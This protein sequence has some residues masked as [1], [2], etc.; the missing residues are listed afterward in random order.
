MATGV[1]VS[2][3]NLYAVVD[4]MADTARITQSI[5]EVATLQNGAVQIT[6]AVIE[7]AVGLGVSCNNPPGGIAGL[8]YTHTFLAGSGD[9]PYTFSISAGALPPGLSLNATTGVASGTPTSPGPFS[10]TVTVT[11]TF[12]ATA[13]VACSILIAGNVR[14][15]LYGYKVFKHRP[16]CA[17]LEELPELPPPPKRVL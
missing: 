7:V 5:V 10:F 6:Q 13:S 8:P 11:D 3:L 1:N 9:P 16:V 12:T 17:N 4:S 2:K 15:S 14:I